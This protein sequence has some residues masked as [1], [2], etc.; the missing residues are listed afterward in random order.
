MGIFNF[1]KGKK[2]EQGQGKDHITHHCFVL[3]KEPQSFDEPT[4]QRAAAKV[5]GPAC[6]VEVQD[7]KMVTIAQGS[8]SIGVLGLIP[9]P[10]PNGEAEHIAQGNPLWPDGPA[11]VAWHTSHVIIMNL[12]GPAQT[13]VESALELS[14]LA[15]V[16]LELFD[17]IGVYWGNGSVCH[18]RNVFEQF[19]EGRSETHLP[20]AMWIRLQPVAVSPNELGLYT[21]GMNQFGLMDLEVERCTWPLHELFGLV[22]G[23]A[24]YLVMNGPVIRDGETVGQSAAQRILVRQRKSLS[25]PKRTVYKLV[26]DA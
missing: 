13:A 18:S 17:G 10:I 15:L 16:A 12:R 1:W 4:A 24:T 8:D 19:C 23:V 11:E 20:V 5:F 3:C 6:S 14:R 25:Q 21:L 2:A 26:F 9:R 22:E 7:G